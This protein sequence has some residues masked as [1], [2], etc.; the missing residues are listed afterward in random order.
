MLQ[1]DGRT[2]AESTPILV[3]AKQKSV[4][5]SD[6]YL[7]LLNPEI[8]QM[9][10]T[11][12]TRDAV[13]ARAVGAHVTR[14]LIFYSDITTDMIYSTSRAEPRTWR[15]IT[16]NTRRVEGNIDYMYEFTCSCY[17]VTCFR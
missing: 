11:V 13:D 10:S 1:A 2:C 15:E 3:Y 9:R 7:D 14:G 17:D 6:L 8:I 12:L 4:M 5:I 16:A